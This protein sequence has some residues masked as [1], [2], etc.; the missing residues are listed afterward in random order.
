VQEVDAQKVSG[1]SG[2]RERQRDGEPVQIHGRGVDAS[3]R[4]ARK[5]SISRRAEWPWVGRTTVGSRPSTAHFTPTEVARWV[6]YQ[7]IQLEAG[8]F[9]NRTMT[10]TISE[11]SWRMIIFKIETSRTLIE[12]PSKNWRQDWNVRTFL[13]ALEEVYALEPKDRF[14]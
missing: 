12:N 3:Q 6:A 2:S 1:F 14:M 4:T 13:R 7:R 9:D 8:T 11:K 10:T 5:M